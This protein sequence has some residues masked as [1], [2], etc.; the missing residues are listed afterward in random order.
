[1]KTLDEYHGMKEEE[2][3]LTRCLLVFL[4]SILAFSIILSLKVDLNLTVSL[5]KKEDRY[6]TYLS[7]REI[8]QIPS[9][10]ILF[11]GKNKYHYIFTLNEEAEL[12][13]QNETYYLVKFQIKEKIDTKILS[14]RIRISRNTIFERI[15]SLWKEES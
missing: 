10:G 7:R 11:V 6:E 8:N 14:S 15:F 1:M 4:L 5:I 2:I 3:S 12:A 9:Q 13:Y